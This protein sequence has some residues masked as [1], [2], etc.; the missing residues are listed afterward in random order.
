MHGPKGSEFDKDMYS[1]GVYKEI[2][3]LKKIVISDYFSDANGNKIDPKS[4]GMSPDFPDD[5][6]VI[7]ISRFIKRLILCQDNC[8]K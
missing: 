8:R 1:A 7:H 2:I 6:N 4:A 3:P 5:L